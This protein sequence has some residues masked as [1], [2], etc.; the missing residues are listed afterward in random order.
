MSEQ[1][2]RRKL[3]WLIAIRVAIGTLLLGSAVLIQFN[4]PGT[5]PAGSRFST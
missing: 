2:M 1:E 5:R 4:V 3:C